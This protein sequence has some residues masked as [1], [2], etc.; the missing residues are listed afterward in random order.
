MS[1]DLKYDYSVADEL[2]KPYSIFAKIYALIPGGSEVLDVGCHTG[3]F[4]ACLKEK[5]CRVAGIEL[6]SEAAARARLVL[7]DVRCASAEEPATFK[8]LDRRYDVI[9]F[10]D[11]LEHCRSPEE[12]LKSVQ[13]A[14]TQQGF[15]IAS[16]PNIANWWVRKNLFFGRF[17]YESIGIMDETHL[18]FYTIDTARKLFHD[19]GYNIELMEHRYSFPFFRVRKVIGGMLAKVLG[20]VLPGLFSY[21]MVIKARPE[22]PC[23]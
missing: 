19:A 11:V 14:L 4:G 15:V 17:E 5:G 16:I 3:R 6:N 18:R 20:P 23:N 7:D 13:N 2:H 9:L 21:Q 8:E 22:A 10:L 1:E 12:V